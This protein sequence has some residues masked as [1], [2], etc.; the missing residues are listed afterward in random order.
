MPGPA[1]AGQG[2]PGVCR[3]PI[4]RGTGRA[5]PCWCR[6]PRTSELVHC[7]RASDTETS[8][9]V[10]REEKDEQGAAV[11]YINFTTDTQTCQGENRIG[12]YDPKRETMLNIAVAREEGMWGKGE[13]PRA[14]QETI[15]L[16]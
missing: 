15:F 5:R 8:G 14:F 3:H 13:R 9:I 12:N 6:A 16:I 7:D 4:P 11:I 1:G 2:R 10:R